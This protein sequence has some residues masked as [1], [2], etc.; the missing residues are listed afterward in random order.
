MTADDPLVLRLERTI[1]APRG[2]V[3]TALTDPEGLR[4]WWGPRG[5][6]VPSVELDLEVGGRY[7]IAMQPPDGDLFHLSGE[8]RQVEPP[9][10]LAYSFRWDPPHPDDRE[11]VVTLSL[12]ERGAETQLRLTHCGFSTGERYALHRAGWTE[13]F[14]RLEQ[15]LG[16]TE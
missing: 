5:F 14:E 1:A 3:Y 11:T 15:A 8:F 9:F 7:R 6:T 2:V 13:S 4:R 10:R 12:E 16:A